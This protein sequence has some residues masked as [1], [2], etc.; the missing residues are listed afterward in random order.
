MQIDTIWT[1]ID[2]KDGD[3]PKVVGFDLGKYHMNN[4]YSSVG[5][6]NGKQWYFFSKNFLNFCEKKKCAKALTK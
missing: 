6:K 2:E 1:Q 4:F 5:H 3:C